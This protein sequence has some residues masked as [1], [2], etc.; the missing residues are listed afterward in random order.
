MRNKNRKNTCQRKTITHIRQYL[1]SS[2]ICLRPRNCRDFTIIREKFK[3]WQYS[4]SLS[5]KLQW[6]N[7]NHQSYVFYIMC[8]RFTMGYKMGQNFF[9]GTPKR[10]VHEHYSLGLSTQARKNLPLKTMQHYSSWDGSSTGSNIIRL[11]KSPTLPIYMGSIPLIFNEVF[12]L[13]KKEKKKKGFEQENHMT[14]TNIHC[15][16]LYQ[17]RQSY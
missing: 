8:T 6:Q 1:R 3:V 5:Q 4:F 11:H 13:K 12:T 17:L 14:S 10:L 15:M 9:R 2:A 16:V 7:P